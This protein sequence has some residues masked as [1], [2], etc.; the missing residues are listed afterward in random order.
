MRNLRQLADES[1]QAI[2]I[3]AL[4][5][6]VLTAFVGIA[7]DVGY[8][9]YEKRRLQKAADAAA[10]AGALEVRVCGT[11]TNC[12]AMKE[13]A[14]SAL[15][16]NGFSG[17]TADGVLQQKCTPPSTSTLTLTINNPVC[18]VAS[19]PNQQQSPTVKK[20]NYVEALVTET[21]P[22][23]FSRIL[24]F[25]GFKLSARA[26]AGH[27]LGGPCIYALDPSA[28]G[29][30]SVSIGLGF[31]SYCGVVVESSSPTSVNCLLGL[32]I[33]A[34][35]VQVSPTGGGASLVCLGNTHVTQA[36]VPIPADPLAY[37]PKPTNTS[38]VDPTQPNT[39]TD[40]YGSKQQINITLALL[41]KITFHPGV[42]CGG[43]A[44]TAPVACNITFAPGMYILNNGP[45]VLLNLLGL[46]VPSGLTTSGLTITLGG[47]LGSISGS[48][49]TFYNAGNK[50]GFSL[51]GSALGPILGAVELSAPTSG[52]Y[53]GILFFQPSFGT[54]GDPNTNPSGTF[55]VKTLTG[56]GINGVVY[57]PGALVT[58]G[59]AA[60]STSGTYNG[61]VADKIQFNVNVLSTINNDYSTLQSGSPFNGDRS[62]LVQ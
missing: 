44:I 55:L 29:A 20:A 53:G 35:E 50:G 38:C 33:T 27:G 49:V 5:M 59:V 60:V 30:L 43:I 22:G 28:S 42:Y 17:I 23:Y 13:A 48:E 14:A 25:T 40:Y 46:Y 21:K 18:L 37:L 7:V 52:N 34:P 39:A 57:E 11:Q 1:G 36:P 58:Y 61:I 47:T 56:R 8:L 4:C 10:L 26:E 12:K 32:G 45:G 31:K 16:E 24:G 6:V 54:P 2:V 19:D 3:V 15:S 62:A 41:A 51:T 9:R